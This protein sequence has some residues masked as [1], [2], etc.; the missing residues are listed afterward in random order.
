MKKSIFTLL[1]ICF[2]ITPGLSKNGYKDFKWGMTSEQISKIVLAPTIQVPSEDETGPRFEKSEWSI[3]HEELHPVSL[4]FI[5]YYLYENELENLIINPQ[6][7]AVD[8]IE[9]NNGQPS[10]DRLEFFFSRNKL[11]GVVTQ[12]H[13]GYP[14]KYPRIINELEEKYGEGFPIKYNSSEDGIVEGRVWLDNKRYVVWSRSDKSSL[15]ALEY[16]T[17]LD[18]E[19]SKEISNICIQDYRKE[20]SQIRS[21]LD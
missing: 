5:M 3:E 8:F 17:Y 9:Y 21:R 7:C 16:V 12:F 6:R 20:K 10:N 19:W 13:H 18:V 14:G 11:V 1:I 4:A 2:I 15:F